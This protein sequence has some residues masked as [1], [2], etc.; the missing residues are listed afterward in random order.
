MYASHGAA[1]SARLTAVIYLV[2]EREVSVGSYTCF[3]QSYNILLSVYDQGANI[4]SN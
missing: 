4:Q 1:V 3:I 2:V